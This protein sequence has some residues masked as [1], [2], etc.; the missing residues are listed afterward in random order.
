MKVCQ[1]V[2]HYRMIRR[3]V[4]LSPVVGVASAALRDWQTFLACAAVSVSSFVYWSNPV[5]GLRRN[6]DMACVS[7]CLAYNARNSVARDCWPSYAVATGAGGVSYAAARLMTN[8]RAA[9]R[10]HCFVHVFGNIG[11][12]ILIRRHHGRRASGP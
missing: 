9:T 3:A 2:A 5:R 6:A 11:N 10:M 12:I 1:Q 8:K 7:L 4:W